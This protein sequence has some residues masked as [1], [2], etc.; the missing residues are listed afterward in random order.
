MFCN[1]FFTIYKTESTFEKEL[2][3]KQQGNAIYDPVK[4][5]L[6]NRNT[7]EQNIGKT[8]FGEVFTFKVFM[9]K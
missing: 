5:A 4:K 7:E 1:F 8:L 2:D 3:F 9:N 6:A